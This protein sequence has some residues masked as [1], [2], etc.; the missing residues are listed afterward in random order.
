MGQ[1]DIWSG[2]LAKKLF[3]R[4]RDYMGQ[5]EIWWGYWHWRGQILMTS[6]TEEPWSGV[7]PVDST[8]LAWIGAGVPVH[9]PGWWS[10][11]NS[12]LEASLMMLCCTMFSCGGDGMVVA[13]DTWRS[14]GNSSKSMP[15]GC[16]WFSCLVCYHE[17]CSLHLCA[18][19]YTL[20]HQCNA[21][22]VEC[23]LCRKGLN[24]LTMLLPCTSPSC[25]WTLECQSY[26][27]LMYYCLLSSVLDQTVPNNGRGKSK[28]TFV[29]S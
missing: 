9:C 15:H 8:P 6:D 27:R 11:H 21:G 19:I 18:F 3:D 22:D 20:H 23:L 25:F 24:R 26:I 17:L 29:L 5:G 4:S 13:V 16:S 2:K 7:E 12:I 28:L 1:G 10:Q 14:P